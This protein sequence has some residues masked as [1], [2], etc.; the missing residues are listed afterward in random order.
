MARMILETEELDKELLHGF[1]ARFEKNS[2]R[3]DRTDFEQM[4]SEVYIQYSF[5]QRT[6]LETWTGKIEVE[7]YENNFQARGD[8]F[9]ME[10]YFNSYELTEPEL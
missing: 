10:K 9:L 1:L 3:S 2:F 7:V 5:E 4:N 8:E 6:D